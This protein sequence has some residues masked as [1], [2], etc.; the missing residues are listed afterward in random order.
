MRSCVDVSVD[1]DEVL[2]QL[3]P[4]D[5]IDHLKSIGE[6]DVMQP[7]GVAFSTSH[8]R[9]RLESI[10]HEIRMGR[11]EYAKNL[12]IDLIEDLFRI[13]RQE[14]RVAHSLAVTKDKRKNA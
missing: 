2:D 1:V 7:Q 13:E 5:L 14:A 11:P 12:V 9:E 4:S 6:F 10:E 3:E 8:A